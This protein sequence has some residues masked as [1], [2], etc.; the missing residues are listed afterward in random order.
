MGGQDLTEDA[1]AAKMSQTGESQPGA[2]HSEKTADT[3]DLGAAKGLTSTRIQSYL[4]EDLATSICHC[5]PRG[6]RSSDQTWPYKHSDRRGQVRTSSH[7]FSR[8]SPVS[9]LL[10]CVLSTLPRACCKA[11]ST[12]W[13]DLRWRMEKQ[14]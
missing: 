10:A 2:S 13:N 6:L 7:S 1:Q 8:Q 9:Q 14:E 4:P 11:A 5:P 12:D 3:H